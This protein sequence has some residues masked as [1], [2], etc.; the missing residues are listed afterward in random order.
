MRLVRM[1]LWIVEF[2]QF[3]WE[4]LA[5]EGYAATGVRVNLGRIVELDVSAAD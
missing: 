3:G 4:N 5:R 2:E 1:R